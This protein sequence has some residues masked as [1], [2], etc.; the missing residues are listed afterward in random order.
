MATSPVPGP[1]TNPPPV[2]PQRAGQVLDPKWLNAMRN[3]LVATLTGLTFASGGDVGGSA[4]TQSDG[5]VQLDL[6]LSDTT[7]TA[8]SYGDSTHVAK[9]TVDAKGRLTAAANVAIAFPPPIFPVVTVRPSSPVD[10]TAVIDASLAT[11][12]PI[13]ALDT[14]GTGWIDATGAAV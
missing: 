1:G 11:P 4:T 10:G 8:A 9:F 13:W 7:V 14:S 12:R 2:P 6:I 5:S 3:R